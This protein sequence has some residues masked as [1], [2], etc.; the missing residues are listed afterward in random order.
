MKRSTQH[1]K[2]YKKREKSKKRGKKLITKKKRAKKQMES[3]TRGKNH[4]SPELIKYD[5]KEREREYIT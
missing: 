5:I 3:F 2:D 4:S 1:I